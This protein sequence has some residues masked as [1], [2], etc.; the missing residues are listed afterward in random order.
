[1]HTS[2]KWL[3]GEIAITVVVLT[4]LG[5]THNAPLFPYKVHK[6][7]HIFGA[8][9]FLGNII[10]TGVW[11]LLAERTR[12]AAIL[13]FASTVVNWADVV[14]TAPGI[15][16]LLANGLILATTWGGI[17]G[18]SWITV[19]LALFASS[20]VVWAVFLIPDQS[21]L[22]RLSANAQAGETL[23]KPFFQALHRWYFWGT[24]ATILPLISLGLMVIKP[25]FW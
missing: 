20:G 9:I 1:M 14:F 19:A 13:Q 10:V 4:L 6:V 3:I 21:R 24:V 16:L 5:I 22:I 23:P 18:V 11:M 25:K 12:E 8:V 17:L 15:L 7:L 2:T